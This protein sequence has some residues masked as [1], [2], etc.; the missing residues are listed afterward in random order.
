MEYVEIVIRTATS[1]AELCALVLE[2]NGCQGAVIEDRADIALYQRPEGEWDMIEDGIAERMDEDVLV[3]GYIP[4]DERSGERVAA[5][6]SRLAELAAADLGGMDLGKASVSTS[7]VEDTDWQTAW[8]KYYK[9]FRVG[10]RLV[11]KPSWEGYEEQPDD[12]VLQ[13]DPGL[14][15]GTGTH[16]TT[17]LCMELI[18]EIAQTSAPGMDVI[19]V[20]CGTGILGMTAALLG[21]SRVLGV[22]IDPLA[23]RVAEENIRIAGLQGRMQVRQ[24]DLLK[25]ALGQ[26]DLCVA[27]IIADVIIRLAPA[28]AAHLKGPKHFIASGIIRDRE[29]D[30]KTALAACGFSVLDVRR[31]GE[32]VA[33]RAR[34]I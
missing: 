25:E 24:G 19:D 15:F 28:L 12:V 29:E 17:S 5:V 32:W 26:F 34:L 18:E 7:G 23:V 27:N 16:E 2:E 8:R 1:G 21:A 3:K 4:A 31:A 14:A 22:D 10:R 33:I 13:I 9:P 20:G 6:R 30:V 11:V